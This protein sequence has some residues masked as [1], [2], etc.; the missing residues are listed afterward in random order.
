LLGSFLE[1]TPQQLAECQ[2]FAGKEEHQQQLRRS[3]HTVKGT[4]G[5]FGLAA[6]RSLAFQLEESVEMRHVNRQ[7]D[8]VNQ[9]QAEYLRWMAPL[10]AARRDL[11]TPSPKEFSSL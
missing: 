11:A 7:T 10:S 4:A 3:A 8:L 5:I 1:S 6:M 2:Q 9:L